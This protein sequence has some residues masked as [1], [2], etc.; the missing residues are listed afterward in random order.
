[1]CLT[2]C[3]CRI[4]ATLSALHTVLRRPTCCPAPRFFYSFSF[5]RITYYGTLCSH[6]DVGANS[7]ALNGSYNAFTRTQRKKNLT[8]SIPVL[9]DQLKSTEAI[10]HL[11][12]CTGKLRMMFWHSLATT[13]QRFINATSTVS[14][15]LLTKSA[16]PHETALVSPGHL[17][18][19]KPTYP[20]ILL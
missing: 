12:A 15:N 20:R 11:F 9:Q 1:M 2:G 6:T 13:A 3:C 17:S 8:S 19:I 16:N 18:G 14:V 7:F 10:L 4:T 5:V